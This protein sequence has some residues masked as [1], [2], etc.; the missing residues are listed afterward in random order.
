[1]A[2]EDEEDGESGAGEG[3]FT[4]KTRNMIVDRWKKRGTC[5]STISQTREK[6]K[7]RKGIKKIKENNER[8][9]IHHDVNPSW[10]S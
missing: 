10:S 6:G 9:Q 5:S 1:M 4:C 7:E 2:G 8:W 3:R